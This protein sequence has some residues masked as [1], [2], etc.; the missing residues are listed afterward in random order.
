VEFGEK[1]KEAFDPE[2]TAEFDF[3]AKRETGEVFPTHHPVSL[4]KDHDGRHVGLISMVRDTSERKK[5]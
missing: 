2:G 4:L 5:H 1:L 3:R